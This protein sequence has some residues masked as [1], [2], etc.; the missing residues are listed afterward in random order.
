MG[1]TVLTP[2]ENARGWWESAWSRSGSGCSVY[3]AKPSYQTD[4]GC[5]HR[6][7]NDVAAVAEDLSVYDT[8][9]AIGSGSLPAWITVGG[10]SASTP[11]IAAVEALSEGAERSLGP[12][13][14]YQSPGR[15][16]TSSPEPTAAAST[17]SV[18]RRRWL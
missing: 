18:H 10:T 13:A 2:A 15:S 12:A 9:H 17:R 4:S 6:T 1:G 3:E 5:A 16:S 14:F 7:T 11:I 8:T